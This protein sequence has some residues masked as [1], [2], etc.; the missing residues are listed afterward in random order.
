M[1]TKKATTKK[2]TSS[3]AAVAKKTTV[4]RKPTTTSAP[5]RATKPASVA[6][7]RVAKKEPLFPATLPN[8]ILAELLGTFILTIAAFAA[9]AVTP[10]MFNQMNGLTNWVIDPLF[11]GIVF[12]VL[13]LG[14]GAV[15]GA[16][17]NPA[18]TFGLWTMRKLK[19]VMVP[20]YWGSQFLGAL[21]AVGVINVMTSGQFSV[22]LANFTQFNLPLF[23]IELIGMAI[24]MFGA[25]SVLN[26]ADLSAGAKSFGIGM[27]LTIGLVVGVGLLAT[28]Q[29]TDLKKYKEE[30]STSTE[31]TKVKL[32]RTILVNGPVLNPAVALAVHENG[33]DQ[34]TQDSNAVLS[35]RF[36]LEVIIGT[37]VGA[38]LGGNL[39]LLTAYRPK[40]EV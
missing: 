19:T 14:I 27:A 38:A 12:A 30:A 35:S 5:A 15:S 1:A 20:V 18:V 33:N 40:N 31:A 21:L 39:F 23:F 26:R 25:A 2:S 29:K 4:K 8:I 36:G 34:Q 10:I 13:V 3:R 11:I 9:F 17:V 6:E 32:S 16:H 22:S 7:I 37:L 28:V 24:F